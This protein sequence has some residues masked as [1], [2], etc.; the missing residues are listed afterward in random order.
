MFDIISEDSGCDVQLLNFVLLHGGGFSKVGEMGWKRQHE[1]SVEWKLKA[2]FYLL[3][4][5]RG[6]SHD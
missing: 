5:P 6:R 1:E 3:L 2:H 4:M